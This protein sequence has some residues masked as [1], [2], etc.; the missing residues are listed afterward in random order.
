MDWLV[1]E[2]HRNRWID[3]DPKSVE[4]IE[5]P[6]SFYRSIIEEIKK[7][8]SRVCLSTLYLGTG[9]LEKELVNVLNDA[10]NS[11]PALQATVLMDYLRGTRG[12]GSTGMLRKT[13]GFPN[14][15]VCLYHTPELRGALKKILGERTNEIVGLQHMK[16][17]IFD[18]D[19]LISGANL[20]ETYFTDRQDRYVL[21]RNNRVL[22]DFFQELVAAV[23]SCSF[24]LQSDGSL[25]VHEKCGF[26]PFE[27]DNTEYRSLVRQRVTEVISKFTQESNTTSK[28]CTQV[29]PLVQ[30]GPFG[31]NQ[32]F[33]LMQRLFAHKDPHMEMSIAS[34]YFNLT[35]EYSKII[36]K[37]GDY[38]LNVVFASPQANGF[39]NGA[40]LSGYI[41]LVY[42]Y[43]SQLFFDQ[44][45]RRPV[46]LFEYKRDGWSFHAKGIWLNYPEKPQDYSATLF[47]SSNFGYRS[48]HRDLEAQVL[49]VTKDRNLKQRLVEEKNRLFEFSSVVETASFKRVDHQIPHWVRMFS[50]CFRNFF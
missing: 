31:I 13:A 50:R 49:L 47:G 12:N 32:E 21:V 1:G 43:V 15:E 28:S 2:E 30:M 26:H 29:Y 34:G 6:D 42:V 17:Y 25:K 36:A 9:R 8:Q 44:M 48:V 18:D 16:I 45:R 41:P 14:S 22:A 10:V 46:K 20:S 7:A 38:S 35:D 39:F 4:L 23:S 37:E 40:A 5:G 33:D 11:R 24:K 27:G 3:V 19:V